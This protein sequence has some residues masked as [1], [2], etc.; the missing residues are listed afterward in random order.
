MPFIVPEPE[1]EDWLSE[2]DEE[3]IK[4]LMQP[5][6]DGYLEAVAQQKPGL[7]PELF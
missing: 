6:P 5:Y 3:G 4:T 1:W 7:A 2:L